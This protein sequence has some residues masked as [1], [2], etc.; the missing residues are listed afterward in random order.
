MT[1]TFIQGHRGARKRKL[2]CQLSQKFAFD[3]NG[4]LVCC[5]D[6]LVWWFHTCFIL[7]VPFS[8]QGRE[9]DSHDFVKKTNKQKT[10]KTKKIKQKNFNISLYSDIYEC[11]PF[12][13]GLMIET[14]ELYILTSVWMTLTSIQGHSCMRNQRLWCPFSCKFQYRF[15]WNSACCHSLLVCWSS[16]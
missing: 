12:K 13:L 4:F 3:L 9:P 11:V 5:W 10:P 2:L 15:G 16:C 8:I 6:L 1:V 14:S 7:T